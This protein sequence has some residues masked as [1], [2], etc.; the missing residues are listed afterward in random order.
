MPDRIQI[1]IG[2]NNRFEA[3]EMADVGQPWNFCVPADGRVRYAFARR[4]N[5][6]YALGW[7]LGS[8][9]A[10]ASDRNKCPANHVPRDLVATTTSPLGTGLT[11]RD[12]S[13]TNDA[14]AGTGW[15]NFLNVYNFIRMARTTFTQN[16]FKQH[17]RLRDTITVFKGT[18]PQCQALSIKAL[19]SQPISFTFYSDLIT[20]SGKTDATQEQDIQE[21]LGSPYMARIYVNLPSWKDSSK[22]NAEWQIHVDAGAPDSHIKVFMQYECIQPGDYILEASNA[23]TFT[24]SALLVT[25]VAFV[26]LLF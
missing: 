14:A 13:G 17:Y 16:I 7:K 10:V 24:V 1:D 22:A 11:K 26:A 23:V 15:G 19:T 2:D 8:F 21:S 9:F 6:R 18:T 25:L 5:G 4:W 3:P 20:Y 12:Y